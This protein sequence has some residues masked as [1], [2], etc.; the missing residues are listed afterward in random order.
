MLFCHFL[1]VQRLLSRRVQLLPCSILLQVFCWLHLM[2]LNVAFLKP[3][4]AN[5]LISLPFPH[6]FVG[7]LTLSEFG[8]ST[9]LLQRQL[10]KSYNHC[11]E[12]FPKQLFVWLLPCTK[13]HQAY[14]QVD[15][16]FWES[17]S[18]LLQ[19]REYNFF[20]EHGAL[21]KCIHRKQIKYTLSIMQNYL[22]L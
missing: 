19:Q 21:C 10:S 8:K 22:Q 18:W 16:W 3:E 12:L 20:Q 9:L 7:A 17:R 5:L 14:L 1:S 13:F 4:E 15:H 11:I 2:G 6:W